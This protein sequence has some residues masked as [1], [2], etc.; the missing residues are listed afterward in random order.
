MTILDCLFFLW[1][2]WPIIHNVL[3]QVK[4]GLFTCNWGQHTFPLAVCK[5]E[6]SSSLKT[7]ALWDVV[8][9]WL[10]LCLL[11]LYLHLLVHNWKCFLEEFPSQCC[12]IFPWNC[13]LQAKNSL[14]W[15]HWTFIVGLL[16]HVISYR[17]DHLAP[18]L[19]VNDRAFEECSSYTRSCFTHSPSCLWHATGPTPAPNAFE[20]SCTHQSS[21]S[22]TRKLIS[23]NITNLV[24]FLWSWIN[25]WRIASHCMFQSQLRVPT[26][27]EL[28]FEFLVK[29]IDLSPF[30]F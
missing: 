27:L 2:R 15:D 23:L 21:L 3:S 6:M 7:T 14:S 16:A 30:F 1:P 20:R 25:V 24:F 29:G 10:F 19:T 22:I 4:C 5:S 12:R 17:Q 18:S 9:R 26:H 28:T 8:E 13:V 11:E